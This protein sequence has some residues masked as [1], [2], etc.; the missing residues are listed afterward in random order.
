MPHTAVP[1]I[2][3]SAVELVSLHQL[4]VPALSPSD[5]TS[6]ASSPS[7]SAPV[8]PA[9][10]LPN[11]P[12]P[13]PLVDG[14]HQPGPRPFRPLSKSLSRGAV[15]RARQVLSGLGKRKRQPNADASAST[16]VEVLES[17]AQTSQDE[18]GMHG[19]RSLFSLPNAPIN[20]TPR[21]QPRPPLMRSLARRGTCDTL[22]LAPASPVLEGD[23]S[24]RTPTPPGAPWAPP[25]LSPA[26]VA[27]I[28]FFLP[29]C[30]AVG[31]AIALHPR[32]I[33]PL[34]CSAPSRFEKQVASAGVV[35]LD[36]HDD[37]RCVW[38]VLRGEEEQEI[39]KACKGGVVKEE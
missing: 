9:D 13:D 5:P 31:T 8:T 18:L 3:T 11:D 21:M 24:I 35:N 32:A 37:A 19:S 26:L 33:G 25:S 1:H 27:R 17:D 34:C 22:P 20:G 29:W 30:L 7:S 14:K 15:R 36:W 16:G 38:R 10:P 23:V 2:D 6:T 12:L 4:S 39:L 28:V